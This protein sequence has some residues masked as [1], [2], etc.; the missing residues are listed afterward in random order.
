MSSS[1]Q[2]Q[3]HLGCVRHVAGD[4][5]SRALA[6]CTELQVLAVTG[7]Y[8]ERCLGMSLATLIE[9]KLIRGG[10]A[11]I[12][13][14]HPSMLT[15]SPLTERTKDRVL[16]HTQLC[17]R[18][19]EMSERFHNLDFKV[20]DK[21]LFH[22]T[23]ICDCNVDTV[24]H[25]YGAPSAS[26]TSIAPGLLDSYYRQEYLRLFQVAAPYNAYNAMT[27]TLRHA[28]DK[29]VRDYLHLSKDASIPY[30]QA[31]LHQLPD[32]VMVEWKK[33]DKA[34]NA[35][36]LCE[37]RRL[38]S[39]DKSKPFV[40]IVNGSILGYAK[41]VDEGFNAG[42]DTEVMV[43]FPF[44]VLVEPTHPPAA[45]SQST[46]PVLPLPPAAGTSAQPAVQQD[47]LADRLLL[48][49]PPSMLIGPR[50]SGLDRFRQLKLPQI[51]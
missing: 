2:Q 21:P 3:H 13:L 37:A 28:R 29:L 46:L 16:M 40:V 17:Q 43:Q 11:Q 41:S 1:E 24:Q 27:V 8:V 50:W 49:K 26:A 20:V 4:E 38:E 35:A 19:H 9:P 36:A 30:S 44:T 5:L 51:P 45:E 31:L 18:L 48:S 12:L 32:H 14:S 34:L 15:N 47:N 23:Y 33:L 6:D 39:F 10:H 25:F 7:S 22:A 42:F